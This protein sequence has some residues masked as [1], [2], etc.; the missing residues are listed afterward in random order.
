MQQNI[1]CIGSYELNKTKG[2]IA[3]KKLGKTDLNNETKKTALFT[4]YQHLINVTRLT[5]D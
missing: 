3:L 5:K 2:I 1:G 4:F